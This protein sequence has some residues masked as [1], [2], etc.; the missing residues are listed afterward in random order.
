MAKPVEDGWF[1]IPNI[2]GRAPEKEPPKDALLVVR[3]HANRV[4]GSPERFTT[5]H[6][7]W[8]SPEGG[9]FV[10]LVPDLLREVTFTFFHD[11]R[12]FSAADGVPAHV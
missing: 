11:W 12:V 6:L 1:A 8:W 10:R 4:D 5:E 9:C 3:N 7:A 2:S